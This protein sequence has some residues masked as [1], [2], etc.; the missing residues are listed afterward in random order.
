MFEYGEK[1]NADIAKDKKF[2]YRNNRL[3]RDDKL[4]LFSMRP[5]LD[6]R[7]KNEVEEPL[8]TSEQP[9]QRQTK[10]MVHEDSTSNVS[11]NKKMRLRSSDI[12]VPS[13]AHHMTDED[14]EEANIANTNTALDAAMTYFDGNSNN[15]DDDD[16]DV[17][18]VKKGVQYEDES[19]SG[20]MQSPAKAIQFL[21]YH[22]QNT[23]EVDHH[24]HHHVEEEGEDED[25]NKEF[26]AD[27]YDE[28][29]VSSSDEEDE[30]DLEIEDATTGG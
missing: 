17:N 22:D 20:K 9:R 6:L 7:N 2:V 25:L 23:T 18:D 29:N 19:S 24:H 1:T 30:E 14:D 10:I 15:S 16:S 28:N 27:D 12:K 5:D 21:Q 8:L 11:G 3:S 26:L 13:R 4:F